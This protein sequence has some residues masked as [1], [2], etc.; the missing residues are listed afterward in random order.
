VEKTCPFCGTKSD[1]Y[2]IMSYGSYIYE[3]PSKYE[4]LFWPFIDG[5]LVYCCRK[6]WFTC[7]AWDFDSI[8]QGVKPDVRKVL[9]KLKVWETNGAYTV[10]PMYYR[11][12]IAEEIYKL[13]DKNEEFWCHFYRVKGFHLA[14][15]DKEE[16]A[17]QARQKAHDIAL[18][19]LK[20]N[21]YKGMEKELYYITGAMKYMLG[22]QE[23]A[24]KDFEKAQKL[25]YAKSGMDKV[26][27]GNFDDFLNRLIDDYFE[28]L[29]AE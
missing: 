13:Y 15:E 27:Q 17:K 5:R 24:L 23:R 11:L 21:T 19:M 7:Y 18:A 1:Y 26:S 16:E 8:P 28:K 10:V 12:K 4:Y 29:R 6:C 14:Y 25:V 20:D 3:Y 22:D 2:E 9:D